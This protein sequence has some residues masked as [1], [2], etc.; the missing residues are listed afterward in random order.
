MMSKL[1][2]QTL[3]IDLLK[4]NPWNPNEMDDETFNRLA[5]EL[6][7]EEG[8]VGYIDPIQVVPIDDGTYRI[9]GGE[10]RWRA[11][12]VL[13]SDTLECVVLSDDMWKEEDLQ[14]FVTTRLNMIKGKMNPEKFMKM[15]LEMSERYQEDAMQALMGITDDSNWQSLIGDTKKALKDMGLPKEKQ[16]EFDDASKKLKTVDDLSTILNKIFTEHGD[17]LDSNFMVFTFGGKE[18]LMVQLPKKVF[19]ATQKRFSAAATDGHD[20]SEVMARVLETWDDVIE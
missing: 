13:G 2:I 4:P 10:H 7:V 1:N 16:K 3:D 20:I 12:K 18:H 11:M 5:Q 17:T 9:I 8:G 19:K 14:K 15:Y 6:D